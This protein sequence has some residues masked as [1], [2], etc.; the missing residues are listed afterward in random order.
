MCNVIDDHSTE[1]F[2][3]MTLPFDQGIAPG[4]QFHNK[5]DCIL[6]IRF[7]HMKNS[8][9][10]KVQ[11]SD[12]ERYVIKCKDPKCGFKLRAS[13]RKKT[14][15]WEIGKMKDLHSCVSRTLSQDH[16]KLSYNVKCESLKSLLHMDTSITVKV[17]IAHIREKFN[18]TISYRKAWRA[19]NKAIESIYG[20]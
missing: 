15:R 17:I 18:Y 19:K 8:M 10:Y 4:M 3:S 1:L 14:D 20:N 7:Y 5:D 11:Q 13:W 2:Q 6:A 12:T 16:R 9:D